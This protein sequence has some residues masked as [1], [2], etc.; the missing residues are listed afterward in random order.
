MPRFY[1][2]TDTRYQDRNG[3]E[4]VII[5]PTDPALYDEEIGPMIDVRF[6]DGHETSVFDDEI[7]PDEA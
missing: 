7:I 6:R 4:I 5:G 3:Q 1:T 2:V